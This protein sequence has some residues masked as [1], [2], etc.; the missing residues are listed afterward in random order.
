M[1]SFT[2]QAL[3]AAGRGPAFAASAL[4]AIGVALLL[5]TPNVTDRAVREWDG[6]VQYFR[7]PDNRGAYYD[8]FGLYGRG[9]FSYRASDEVSTYLRARTQPD[10]TI[11]VW[12]YDP[13]LLVQTG[14]DSPSRFLSFLPLMSRWTP[15]RWHDEFVDDLERERP[16]YIV[17]QRNE[18]AP[19]IT[20]HNI[21]PPLFIP[22][23][24]RFQSLLEREY[25][26]DRSIED[27]T[28][29]RRRS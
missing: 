14:R 6:F 16:A 29:Y 25:E 7:E 17:V 28:L 5:L 15:S 22:L 19:W 3:R 10:D 23:I 2:W 4:A 20:G 13:L 9:T 24:P 26:L 21:D 27:Y 8:R 18:N 12:G 1:A 11:F